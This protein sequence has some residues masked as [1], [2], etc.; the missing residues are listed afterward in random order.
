MAI[1]KVLIVEDDPDIQKLIRMSLTFQGVEEIVLASDGEECLSVVLRVRPDLIL[2][3]VTM[4]RLD[5]YETCRRLKADSQTRCIPVIFLTAKAQRG[6]KEIGLRAGALGY[7]T[8]P[9]D[10]LTLRAQIL[11]ILEKSEV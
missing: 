11:G 2:L 7:L 10:P 9:F 8:K 1:R 3:D 4:P 6:E 5:G